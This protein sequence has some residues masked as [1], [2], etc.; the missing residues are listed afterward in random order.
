[1]G[2]TIAEFFPPVV[3]FAGTPFELNR[4]MLIRIITTLVIVLLFWLG[5][6]RMKLV[7]GR[8]QSL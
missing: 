6:R 5:T 7:P 2:P 1:M 4:V 3:L 8:G